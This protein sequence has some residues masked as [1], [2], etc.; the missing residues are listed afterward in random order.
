MEE[1][2]RDKRFGKDYKLCSQTAISIVYKTGT[3]IKLYP[4]VVHYLPLDRPGKMPFQL[5]FS[6]PKRRF[7]HANERN[8]IKRHL[9][10]SFRNKKLILE[11]AL[12]KQG[13]RLGLFVI[14]TAKEI[15]T[16]VELDQKTERLL[17]QITN[18]IQQDSSTI[19]PTL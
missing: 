13:M 14:Y 18:Q 10:E 15:L 17:R 19:A 16:Q 8:T 1:K 5:V 2:Y 9:R 4:F 6:A 7:K 3:P 12:V 11:E